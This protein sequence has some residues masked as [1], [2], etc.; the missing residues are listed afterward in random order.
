MNG[1]CNFFF[2][3]PKIHDYENKPYSP[4][5]HTFTVLHVAE[6]GLSL[7]RNVDYEVPF[8]KKQVAK[9][10]QLIADLDRRID[11]LERSGKNAEAEF[12][13]E[14]QTIGI[15]ES[16]AV[17][18]GSDLLHA[19]QALILELPKIMETVVEKLNDSEIQNA[20]KYYSEFTSYTTSNKG[21]VGLE[22]LKEILDGKAE[23][24]CALVVDLIEKSSCQRLDDPFSKL[25][26]GNM[27]QNGLLEAN[28]N[29]VSLDWDVDVNVEHSADEA[30]E[31]PIEIN[32]IGSNDAE[33][34]GVNWDI[35]ID[36]AGTDE[37]GTDRDEG[38][39]KDVFKLD[40]L[41]ISR[42]SIL[43]LS[44]AA[45]KL[46]SE[47]TYRSQLLD[48]LHE[49]ESFLN[50]RYNELQ[51]HANDSGALL[52]QDIVDED[53]FETELLIS[54][55]VPKVES[56]IKAV[57]DVL[58][59][60][61]QDRTVMLASIAKSPA[62]CERLANRLQRQGGQASKFRN[63]ASDAKHKKMQAQQQ[64]M[65]DSK[66]LSSIVRKIDATKCT[67]EEILEGKLNRKINIQGEINNILS[68][69]MVK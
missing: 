56:M 23:P 55:D 69:L 42:E 53:K 50:Q 44:N 28:D 13:Q 60:F 58:G 64:L 49:L 8:F 35:E 65:A 6:M 57:K 47:N 63:A 1:V 9:N 32:N 31:A 38:S 45:N 15:P 7:A 2:I 39:G 36:L 40:S 24:P 14:C 68:Q 3:A 17:V 22:I 20:I 30:N 12:V 33:C 52:T 62:N 59:I 4:Y 26:T 41:N 66:K 29:I 21:A 19:I 25:D 27:E 51:S 48:D 67:V 54:V 34:T 37:V 16:F 46:A 18:G 10:Q 61:Q 11:D 5:L 43:E